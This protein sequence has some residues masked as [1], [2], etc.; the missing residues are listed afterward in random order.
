MMMLAARIK[1]D[2]NSSVYGTVSLIMVINGH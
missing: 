2:I 1:L